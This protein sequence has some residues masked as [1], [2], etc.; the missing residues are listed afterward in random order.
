V[1]DERVCPFCKRHVSE[2]AGVQIVVGKRLLVFCG[3]CWAKA[4]DVYCDKEAGD[5]RS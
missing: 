1:S 5:V 4:A 3:P 2:G